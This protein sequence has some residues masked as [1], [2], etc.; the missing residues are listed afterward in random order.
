MAHPRG[1][2]IAAIPQLPLEDTMSKKTTKT[3]KTARK[4]SAAP[5]KALRVPAAK[6]VV[7]PKA[8]DRITV[9]VPEN[10]KRPGT[11]A[12]KLFAAYAAATT[13][14]D[15]TAAVSRMRGVEPHLARVGLRWDQRH[16]YVQ[17]RQAPAS[18]TA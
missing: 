3:T 9:L 13:V 7:S 15:Y 16:G 18:K 1:A 11:V 12:H 5:A 17:V 14:A 6:I 8:E 2:P 4:A 10:P